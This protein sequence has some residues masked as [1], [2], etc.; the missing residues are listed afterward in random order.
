MTISQAPV[1]LC[2]LL[3]TKLSALVGQGK[4]AQLK[5][6]EEVYRREYEAG[7]VNQDRVVGVE[8]GLGVDHQ[9]GLTAGHL[10]GLTVEQEDSLIAGRR[11][12]LSVDRLDSQD[13]GQCQVTQVLCHP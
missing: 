12:G 10:D 8:N 3:V 13:L 11:D 4:Q 7:E 5:L 9:D 2:P 1:C 6:E